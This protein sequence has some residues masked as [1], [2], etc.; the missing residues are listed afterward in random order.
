M[1]DVP[2][3]PTTSTSAVVLGRFEKVIAVV[4]IA[5]FVIF[6][7]VLVVLRDSEH[8]DRLV[9]LFGGLEALV[10][11]AAGA[12]FGNGIQRAQ[13]VQA[14]ET[15][16]RERERADANES[17]AQHGEALAALV[18]A[19]REAA[20]SAAEGRGARPGMAAESSEAR[21]LAELGRVADEWF[22]PTR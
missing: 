16:V 1:T 8:W 4:L 19:K 21:S 7:G 6:I 17:G 2:E 22:P 15:A 20:E 3:T 14:Q 12:L 9:Y 18:R 5:L 13:T 10:F 11:S